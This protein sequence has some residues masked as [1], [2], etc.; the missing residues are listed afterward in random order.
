MNGTTT[1][2]AT[3]T[4]VV[5]ENPRRRKLTVVNNSATDVWLGHG[6]L[7]TG[8]GVLLGQRGAMVDEPDATGWMYKGAWYCISAAGGETLSWVESEG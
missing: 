1:V 5:F 8:N 4:V 2:G 3:S 7:A 6:N